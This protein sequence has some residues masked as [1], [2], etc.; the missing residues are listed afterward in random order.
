MDFL[1]KLID[2]VGMQNIII[3]VVVL[4]VLVIGIFTYRFFRLK[5]YR[6]EL[7]ELE[8]QMN[9]TK[10]LPIQYRLGRVQGIAKNMPEVA[11]K[12]D[13][14]A[15]EFEKVTNFQTDTIAMQITELDDRLF[16]RKLGG[17]KS[18]FT[19]LQEDVDTYE[20]DAKTLLNDI[21]KITEIENIQRLEIIKIKEAYRNTTDNYTAVRF[22]IEDFVPEVPNK[23]ADIDQ[24]FVELENMMNEQKFNEASQFSKKIE[25]DILVLDTHLEELPTFISIVRKYI[26][27]RMKEIADK[28][29]EMES[30]GFSLEVLNAPIRY[31]KV[32][33]D[34][35]ETVTNVKDLRLA[36]VGHAIEVMT[37][38]I[39]SLITDFER[40]EQALV[41]YKEKQTY[42]YRYIDDL[43]VALKE[44]IVYLE[45][46][47]TNYRMDAYDFDM[48]GVYSDFQPIL[49]ELTEITSIINSNNF[50]YTEMISRFDKLLA[51]CKKFE[52]KL[53][54]FNEIKATLRLQEKRALDELD[55]INIVLLE[56]KSEIKNKHLPMINDSYKDYIEDSYNKATEILN[57]T[58]KRPVD[59]ER[60]SNQVD[61][62]RDVI[63][64]LYDNV[65]NL[66]VTA[67]MV[68]DAIIYGNRYRSTFLEVN[69]E[70]TKAELL[71]R[72]GEY[73]KA[74]TTAVDIIEK[75]KPGS[76][77][78][79]VNNNK[80]KV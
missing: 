10:S 68:E 3:G 77:E 47:T 36:D 23:I 6:K 58:K 7:V 56:I 4:V 32:E 66:I 34:L 18:E 22:K 48:K 31:Q 53:S 33:Q 55:N 24:R 26:P 61:A 5:K 1:N 35:N 62:A 15:K 17:I 41:A 54:S 14:Y 39:N 69:T 63:Y 70:L 51:K 76:Y 57:F 43:D 65:H 16:S 21:E 19:K 71:F 52:E 8:N 78:R 73:T 64:K 79:L 42:C 27:K 40:E 30:M 29:K 67:E 49:E 59:L 9:A 72:N 44:S 37:E 75:I 28:M 25:K 45:E 13:E 11:A 60:L 20:K 50:A 46:L 12:Y 2:S 74:L 80:E 38:D